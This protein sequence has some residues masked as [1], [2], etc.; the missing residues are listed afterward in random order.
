MVEGRTVLMCLWVNAVNWIKWVS[1]SVDFFSDWD[2]RVNWS[3]Y[4]DEVEEAFW[5]DEDMEFSITSENLKKLI[6]A[7]KEEYPTV[8]KDILEKEKK[9]DDNK[10]EHLT[11]NQR[12]IA[13][14][15][16]SIFNVD[17]WYRRISE[18]LTQHNIETYN[19][20]LY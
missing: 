2:I 18:F 15:F 3:D 20:S 8:M 16:L 19:Y 10:Y 11:E 17:R 14:A 12:I 1:T 6:E 7:L 5:H 9:H 13:F 4:W